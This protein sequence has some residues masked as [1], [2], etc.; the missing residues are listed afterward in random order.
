MSLVWI[1]QRD[2]HGVWENVKITS[3]Q[4]SDE[5]IVVLG[6]PFRILVDGEEVYKTRK[7]LDSKS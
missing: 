4:T 7:K 6:K 5:E 1:Q 2:T 3:I